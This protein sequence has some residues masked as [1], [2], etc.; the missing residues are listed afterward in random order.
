MK[1]AHRDR[2]SQ[3]GSL[4]VS[5]SPRQNVGRSRICRVA[6]IALVVATCAVGARSQEPQPQQDAPPPQEAPQQDVPAAVPL[7]RIV[8]Q[9]PVP[10]FQPVP[11]RD[12]GVGER[13]TL[14]AT[15]RT[16]ARRLKLAESRFEKGI[17]EEAVDLLQTILDSEEDAAAPVDSETPVFRSLKRQAIDL[18][19]K[20]PP[21]GRRVYELKYGVAARGQLEDALKQG[22]W[23]GVEAVSRRY[24]HTAAGREATYRLAAWADDRG[25][26]LEAAL[27][28]QRLLDDGLSPFEPR[29]SLRTA[30]AWSKAGMVDLA[31]KSAERFILLSVDTPNAF[32]DGVAQ[33]KSP[34]ELLAWLNRMTGAGQSSADATWPM[35]GGSAD[36]L[37]DVAP[38]AIAEGAAWSHRLHEPTQWDSARSRSCF[39]AGDRA[40]PPDEGGE[41]VGQLDS[42]RVSSRRRTERG[43]LPHAAQHPGGRSGV[44]TVAMAKRV[45]TRS[46]LQQSGRRTGPVDPVPTGRSRRHDESGRGCRPTCVAESHDRDAVHRRPI[47]LRN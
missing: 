17:Y 36:R 39:E 35:F 16:A 32:P 11:R 38:V 43:D 2:R 24:F 25:E 44:G 37:A 18:L 31:K 42:A 27:L 41:V 29:L 47:R 10:G 12:G 40:R 3:A 22:E 23:E 21:D 9:A 20:L 7:P 19:S 13:P 26:S 6:A 1:A 46:V 4:L 28:F 15:N 33:A 45:A 8:P 14:F 30:A 34:E 5:R